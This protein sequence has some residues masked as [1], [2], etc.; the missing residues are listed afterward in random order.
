MSRAPDAELLRVAALEEDAAHGPPSPVGLYLRCVLLAL[1]SVFAWGWALGTCTVA[2]GGPEVAA[3]R[4]REDSAH[5]RVHRAQAATTARVRAAEAQTARADAA[6]GRYTRARAQTQPVV[7]VQDA[8]HPELAGLPV[9]PGGWGAVTDGADT[10]P[11]PRV[12]IGALVARDSALAAADAAIS[13]QRLALVKWGVVG[14]AFLAERAA[15]D[16]A[17][18]GERARWQAQVDIARARARRW[19]WIGAGVGALGVLVLAR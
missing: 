8:P 2:R 7:V 11:A 1:V 6:V 19:A 16:T 9:V 12:V 4:A 18:A 17:L 15:R 10:L 5:V 13:E 3:L 14:R